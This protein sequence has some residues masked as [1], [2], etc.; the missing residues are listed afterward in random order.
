MADEPKAEPKAVTLRE[1]IS[2]IVGATVAYF[3][4]QMTD[5]DNPKPVPEPPEYVAADKFK[6]EIEILKTDIAAIKTQLLKDV[7]AIRNGLN[8]GS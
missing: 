2:M 8:K 6:A 5:F 3:G 7:E 4:L 1:Y